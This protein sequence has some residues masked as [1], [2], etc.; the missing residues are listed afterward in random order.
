MKAVV[1]TLGCKVNDVESGSMIRGLETLGYS[2]SRELAYADLYIVN[3]CAVTGEAERKSR[4]AI[5]KALKFNPNARVIVCGCASEKSPGA[6]LDKNVF[7]VVGAQSKNRVLDIVRSGFE[8][9]FSGLQ[10]ENAG[11]RYE[12]MPLPDCLKTRRFVKIQDGCNRFCS[13]CVIPYLRGRSRSR[14]LESASEEILLGGAF[15]TVIT[16]IDISDYKDEQGRDLADLMLAVKDAEMRIRLGSLE[17]SLIT[18]RFLNALKQVKRFAPQ[19]HLS[20]QSGSDKVLKSMN[21]RYTRA[22]YLEKCKMIYEAFPSAAITTDIIVGFP[23]ETEEDFEDSLRIVEE[24]GFAQIHAFPYSPRE[25][26]NAYKKYKEL[27]FALKKERVEKLLLKGAEEKKKYMERFVGKVL[28]LV[29]ENC[30]EGFTEGYSENYI[31]VYLEGE[32][33]KR[34]TQVCNQSPFRSK[35]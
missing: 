1:F 12:E 35:L 27:P 19:F 6:F 24:A 30:F 8:K 25:G 10:I 32:I 20:L 9:E 11:G 22:E 3:T 15:E 2:V 4:Q 16:G 28:E 26:T 23:T 21:R 34:P 29:P 14:S 31:R 17:V 18:E 13:Y 33:E 7:A 5:G